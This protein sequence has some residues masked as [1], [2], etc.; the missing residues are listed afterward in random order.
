MS[1]TFI[2]DGS[3]F[4]IGQ[5]WVKTQADGTHERITDKKSPKRIDKVV[6]RDRAWLEAEL[7]RYLS[8]GEMEMAAVCRR[9]LAEWA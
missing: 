3:I 9:L 4:G 6:K 8:H 5:A 7:H 1:D 2:E